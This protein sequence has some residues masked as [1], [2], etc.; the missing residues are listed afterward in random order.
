MKKAVLCAGLAVVAL[1]GFA[2]GASAEIMGWTKS[3]QLGYSKMTED[4][5]PGGSIGGHAGLYA[6]LHSV[7]H[8]GAEVGYHSL[9]SEEIAVPGGTQKTSFSTWR[10][11]GDIMARG[12]TGTVR[13][14]GVGGLGIY[15][16]RGATEGPLG[17]A[18]NTETKFGFHLGG[19]LMFQ[20]PTS[21]VGFGAEARW[22]SVMNG[23]IDSSG[24]ES[25]L[26][27]VTLQA[28]IFF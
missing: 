16:L 23:T 1:G 14:Y 24:N 2:S 17:D 20:P 7:I 22:H 3:V 4:G 21:P 11:T 15:P 9:G 5:A 12:V 27:M 13:P 25:A 19:G 6:A 18:S 10:F 28:G 26:D 8:V